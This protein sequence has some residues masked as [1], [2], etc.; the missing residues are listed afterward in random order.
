MAWVSKKNVKV[1]YTLFFPNYFILNA[2]ESFGCRHF[3][4]MKAFL[5]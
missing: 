5:F 2:G 1:K 4:E 3:E